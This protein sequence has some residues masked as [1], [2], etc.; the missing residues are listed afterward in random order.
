MVHK[1]T[2]TLETE[3]LILRQLVMKDL[4]QIFINCW[5]DFEVWKWTNYKPMK[6]MDD[7][8]NIAEMFTDK[9]LGAYERPT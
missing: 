3:G 6:C 2:I 9:W 5:S 7:V 8:I 1:S 4:E